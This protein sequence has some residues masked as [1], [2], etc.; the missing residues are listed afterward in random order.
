MSFSEWKLQ[1]LQ[2]SDSEM[3]LRSIETT[4]SAFLVP[5]CET[6]AKWLFG[7]SSHHANYRKKKMLVPASGVKILHLES[8]KMAD[9]SEH[10]Y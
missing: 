5:E 1:I 2:I 10:F 7:Q 3:H 9:Q 6:G 8:G 4:V